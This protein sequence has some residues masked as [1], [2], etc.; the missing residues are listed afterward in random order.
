MEGYD[1]TWR[2]PSVFCAALIVSGGF[3]LFS[4]V[5]QLE[6]YRT[7]TIPVPRPLK[8]ANIKTH[9]EKGYYVKTSGCRIHEM[10]PFSPAVTSY[11]KK[12]TAVICNNGTPP[13][14]ESGAMPLKIQTSVLGYYN[15]TDVS[16]LQC[17]Y[18]GFWRLDS[19]EGEKD[20]KLQFK[21]KC[22]VFDKEVRTIGEEFVRVTCLYNGTEIYKDFFAFVPFKKKSTTGQPSVEVVNSNSPPLNVLVIG[23]DA[24]SRLN[25][26]RQMPETVKV[27]EQMQAVDFVGYNKVEDNTF[28]N[29]I[30]VLTGLSQEELQKVCW[31]SKDSKFDDCPFVWKNFS[32]AGYL[33]G[34]AE[35]AAWMGLFT[36]LK[37]GFKKQPTDYF[38][39]PFNRISEQQI[40]NTHSL[41]VDLCVG[42][43]LVYKTFID[44]I[45]KFTSTMAGNR[46][47]YFGFFWSSTISH[48]FLNRPQIADTD[49][50]QLFTDLKTKGVLDSTVLVFLSDHGIRWGAIRNTYQGLVEERLPFLYFVLPEQYREDY[51]QVYANM[52]RN[53][54]QLTTPFDLHET[55]IDLLYPYDLSFHQRSRH[56][57]SRSFS[58]FEY[59]PKNRTCDS[60]G[61]APHWC[62]CQQTREIPRNTTIIKQ[63]ANFTVD[64]INSLLQGYASCARLFLTEIFT[65]RM[66]G[67]GPYVSNTTTHHQVDYLVSLGTSPGGAVFEATVRQQFNDTN[68]DFNLRVT[69]SI[70]RLNL[71]GKQ[72]LCVTDF[73]LKLYCYCI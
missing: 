25:L 12:E 44:Y 1:H 59:I 32:D 3:I 20:T 62:T 19:R 46:A 30:P 67:E 72:S 5:F 70:S 49:F 23:I 33:T 65:A 8:Q 39:N 43:R 52:I 27:L 61:I 45:Y 24:I 41:N 2:L 54:H 11:I 64:H 48:D 4:D 60:A 14:V 18:T 7:T 47:P 26:Q 22:V 58:L 10:D 66:Y 56:Q 34:F 40:G 29:L 28:P 38:W 17:C 71:Y 15:V 13:L 6:T 31:R 69:G 37:A 73:H 55:L 53:T 68:G 35:D 50:S 36:Y 9:L 16:L 42:G 63:V 21:K 57:Q 51:P